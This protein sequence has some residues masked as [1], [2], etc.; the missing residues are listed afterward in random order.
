MAQSSPINPRSVA[1]L[2]FIILLAVTPTMQ[3]EYTPP[4]DS[5]GNE[6]TG[7]T[8]SRGG[9]EDGESM[10]TLLA[11]MTHI[12]QTV[13]TH[14]TFVWYV[15]DSETYSVEFR[16]FSYDSKNFWGSEITMIEILS[17]QGLMKLSLPKNEPGL[18]VGQRYIWEIAIL[19]DPNHPSRDVVAS[20][21]INVVHKP[22]SF[23]GNFA[24][25]GFWY[26]ALGEA[27]E[28]TEKPKLGEVGAKLLKELVNLEE[29]KWKIIQETPEDEKQCRQ[30]LKIEDEKQC[31]Q[32]LKKFIE[33]LRIIAG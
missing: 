14:P 1:Y 25:N 9:C 29:E 13:S 21:Q 31:R 30:L 2:I 22:Q 15:P 26:D 23:D 18:E 27:I 16:L 11:P 33:N 19:C 7:S 28:S 5:G 3:A 8:S 6:S 32:L 17:S 4:A 20:N 10:L 24:E 12:G